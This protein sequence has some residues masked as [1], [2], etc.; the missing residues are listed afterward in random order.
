MI[1]VPKAAS[2]DIWGDDLIG[3][4]GDADFLYSFL[5]GKMSQRNEQGI[6]GSY[7]LNIDAK[8][9][10]GKSFFLDRFAKQLA[11][12]NHIVARVNAW[13]DDH[14]D[15]PFVSVLSAIDSALKPFTKTKRKGG[16]GD[17]WE[18]T[19]KNAVPILTRTFVGV[20]K[21]VV[22]RYV[23]AEF[24]ELFKDGDDETEST[25]EELSKS[26]VEG[27]SVE[28]SKVVDASAEQLIEKFTEQNEAIE[29]FRSK[30]EKA[31]EALDGHKKLPL[32][33]LIDELD[34]CRP[35]YA[36][37]LLERIKHLFDASNVV[38]VFATHNEQ[39]QHSIAGAYGPEFDGFKYLKRFFNKTYTLRQPTAKLFVQDRAKKLPIEKLRCP[40]DEPIDFLVRA[41]DAYSMDLREAEHILEIIEAVAFVWRHTIRIEM[42]ILVPLAAHYYRSGK[43]SWHECYVELSKI[44][45]PFNVPFIPA[46]GRYGNDQPI[47]LNMPQVFNLFSEVVGSLGN[48]SRR[49]RDGGPDPVNDYV[50]D[51]FTKELNSGYQ[52]NAQSIQ[53]SI[54]L[55]ITSAGNFLE[56]EET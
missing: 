24:E 43:W 50:Q 36:I 26:A 41:V 3:R 19:K 38:F 8:W 13:K 35:S 52:S 11:L 40:S 23:G 12:N 25:L 46:N 49:F 14:A 33:I 30:L 31:I 22:K 39:L 55:L 28:I 54:P 48:I 21:T 32:F 16:A 6:K 5:V 51:C 53:A 15:D 1:D 20:G 10:A 17:L 4:K 2:D 27:V 45:P 42:V 56:K 44:Q 9:G 37:S 7:V 18:K 47:E 29:D 34:R